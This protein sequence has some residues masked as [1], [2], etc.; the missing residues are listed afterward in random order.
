[1][2]IDGDSDYEVHDCWPVAKEH[3]L[4]TSSSDDLSEFRANP[5][6]VIPLWASDSDSDSTVLTEVEEDE[7]DR[8][9]NSTHGPIR[10][11][12]SFNR[13]NERDT[14]IVE[15]KFSEMS[16]RERKRS[17]RNYVHPTSCCK[18]KQCHLSISKET[19]CDLRVR[20][21]N[22]LSMDVPRQRIEIRR[23]WDEVLLVG[24]QPCC[25]AFVT[26]A[27]GV[28]KM[29]LYGDSRSDRSKIRIAIKTE[30]A[31]AFFDQLRL[32]NDKMPDKQEYQLYAP[33][34]KCV[35]EWYHNQIGEVVPISKTFFFQLWKQ[36]APDLKLRKYLKF[37][38]CKTCKDLKEVRLTS[39]HIVSHFLC[40]CM[41]VC[42]LNN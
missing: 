26:N 35:W 20:V 32:E 6:P 30:C 24:G 8:I 38:I 14:P 16:A 33:N 1:M 42:I 12:R 11:R 27:F 36:F 34:K 13:H 15:R 22:D 37:T 4:T 9:S 28:S 19:I 41:Y 18:R 39:V 21:W 40:Y 3:C 5:N 31:I 29:Y 23:L 2:D 17:A 25:T 10:R 7:S